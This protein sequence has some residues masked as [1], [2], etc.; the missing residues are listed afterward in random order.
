M[1]SNASRKRVQAAMTFTQDI[2]AT[3]GGGDILALL[4]TV[5]KIGGS[6]KKTHYRY[7]SL[8]GL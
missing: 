1:L 6:T 5:L 7:F 8:A 2:V 4:S 3:L